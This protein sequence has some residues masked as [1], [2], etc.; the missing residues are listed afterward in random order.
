ML[1][2]SGIRRKTP[3]TRMPSA[4]SS[5]TT[6]AGLGK[7][8]GKL[9]MS[10]VSRELGRRTKSLRSPGGRFAISMGEESSRT[11]PTEPST[12][13]LS[14]LAHGSTG[15][16][17]RVVSFSTPRHSSISETISEADSETEFCITSTKHL[18]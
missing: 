18:I 8:S 16:R 6:S 5:A 3:P 11:V 15:E 4:D 7:I 10:E 9:E 1:H 12:P 17:P 13:S 14:S 2:A